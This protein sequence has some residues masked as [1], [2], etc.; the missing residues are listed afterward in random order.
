MITTTCPYQDLFIYYLNGRAPSNPILFGPDFLGCWQEE[1]TAFLFFST[2]ARNQ[3]ENLLQL[4]PN[5]ILLDEF[6][7][8]YAQWQGE[9]LVPFRVGRF[10]ITPPWDMSCKNETVGRK[11][12]HIILDPGV[13]F[14]T[15][16][17]PTT[18]NCLEAL[19]L[20][21]SLAH[22]CSA[23]DLG[24]GTGLLALA[25]SRL[26]CKKTVAVD[27]NFLATKT[28]IKN[29]RHNHLQDAVMV[30]QGR[31]EDFIDSSF[32]LM[33][34]NIHYD[35]MKYLIASQG[36]FT[37]KWF[38]M[39]GLLRS[40]ARDIIY[41]LNNHSVQIIKTWEQDGIWHTLLGRICGG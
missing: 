41:R 17:H 3:V 1:D 13:V 40:Q 2:P 5:L 32:D 7:M 20:V 8:T 12:C 30:V 38:I 28:A 22:P 24:T 34:A 10:L 15:G 19:E 29:V 25:A 6:Q 35:I 36:F 27:L 18:Q 26:G 23:V 11:E 39:S 37:K 14:G 9:K 21:F 31:A 16:T 33:I 4:H